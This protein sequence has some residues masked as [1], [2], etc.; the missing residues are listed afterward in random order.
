MRTTRVLAD[1]NVLFSR[2][3]RDWLLMIQLETGAGPYR[4]YWTEDIL[5]ETMY[6]L[7]RKNPG[8][9]GATTSTIRDRITAVLE[10]GRIEDFAVDGTFSGDPNDQHV[11]A[12]AIAGDIDV[13]LTADRG[14]F[15]EGDADSLPYEVYL[16]DE[17]FVLVDDSVPRVVSEV[18]TRQVE[19]HVRRSG[20][21]DLCAALRRAGCPEF[22][23][24]VRRHVQHM[25][26]TRL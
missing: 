6:Q 3:L 24:R 25:D 20:A 7:R 4:V 5:A 18:A 14:F 23:E 2:T 26:T 9:D 17:F 1:A 12:A 19:Y 8:W 10:G 16:P 21:V 11:H 13:V 15:A 22:A